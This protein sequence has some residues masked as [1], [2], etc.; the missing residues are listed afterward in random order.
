MAAALLRAAPGVAP[1]APDAGTQLRT[2]GLP[3][4]GL[5]LLRVPTAWK[6]SIQ[7]PEGDLPPTITFKPPK[8]DDFAVLVTPIWSPD[9]GAGPPPADRVRDLVERQ[10]QQVL[11]SAEESDLTIR[12]IDGPS[13]HGFIY[14]LTDK[15]VKPGQRQE[16]NYRYMTQGQL[17]V[18][19]L[20]MAVTILA[21]D[22]DGPH[23]RAAIEMLKSATHRPSAANA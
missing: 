17:I 6:D 18:G 3:G 2:Y 21:H 11:G 10:G 15:S 22:K 12:E 5:L 19:D 20:M 13:A 7:Q 9:A 4:H 23:E 8:G 1:V 16:G 14:S